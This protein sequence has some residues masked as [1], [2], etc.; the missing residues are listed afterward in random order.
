MDGDR[1]CV[2]LFAAFGK[3]LPFRAVGYVLRAGELS[4]EVKGPDWYNRTPHRCNDVP[5]LAQAQMLLALSG[6]NNVRINRGRLAKAA[7]LLDRG[8]SPYALLKALV[9][10]DT[11]EEEDDGGEDGGDDDE[12]GDGS[13][14][15]SRHPRWPA[16]SPDSTGG[17]FAPKGS[18]GTATAVSL[19]PLS[20]SGKRCGAGVKEAFAAQ[21][22]AD[23]QRH[24]K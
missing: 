4:S 23:L 22:V 7:A 6:V 18:G 20:G 9:E 8:V 24:C 15:D 5:V 10:E 21:Q 11:D 12:G 19:D 2:L 3:R 16:G 14:F 1:L 17:E 13:D